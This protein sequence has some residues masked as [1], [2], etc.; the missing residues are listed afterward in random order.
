MP[1]WLYVAVS[2]DVTEPQM[3]TCPCTSVTVI[4]ECDPPEQGCRGTRFYDEQGEVPFR[5]SPS[6]S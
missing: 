2:R 4:P 5:K 1:L 3:P 6:P